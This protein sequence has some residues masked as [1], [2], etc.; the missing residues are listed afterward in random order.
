MFLMGITLWMTYLSVYET[1]YSTHTGIRIDNDS[2]QKLQF[3]SYLFT[4]LV[5]K[6]TV[7]T[8]LDYTQEDPDFSTGST[9]DKCHEILMS[10][11]HKIEFIQSLDRRDDF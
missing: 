10:M 6:T 11:I 1:L 4:A 9:D 7:A 2:N 5:P 8:G 3:K